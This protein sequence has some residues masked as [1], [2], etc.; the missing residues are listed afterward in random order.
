MRFF[1]LSVLFL[2]GSVL[3]QKNNKYE[4]FFEKGNGNQSATYSETI[5]FYKMLDKDFQSIEMKEMGLTDSGEPLHIVIFNPDKNFN[6]A[7]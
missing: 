6:F 4:T 3:A 7:E 1:T 5:A 2:A